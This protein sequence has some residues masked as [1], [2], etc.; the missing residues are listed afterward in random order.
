MFQKLKILFFS[1]SVII[2]LLSI[3]NY[4][5]KCDDNINVDNISK[6]K[7]GLLAGLSQNEHDVNF[8]SLDG[9]PNCCSPY[10]STG[11]S[12]YV[13]GIEGSYRLF[14]SIGLQ[15]R[16]LSTSFDVEL[17]SREFIGN[18]ELSGELIHIYSNHLLKSSLTMF[19]ISPAIN[20]FPISSIDFYLAM[21]IN[22]GKFIKYK[23][24]QEESLDNDVYEKGIEY[25]NGSENQGIKRNIIDGNLNV[26]KLL[27]AISP[28]IG[29]TKNISN[30][31]NLGLQLDYNC[32]ISKVI[33]NTAWSLR[34][35]SLSMNISY[36]FNKPDNNSEIN[37][38]GIP[39]EFNNIDT[40]REPLKNKVNEIPKD[41]I[42]ENKTVTPPV[43]ANIKEEQ[44]KPKAECCYV[45]FSYSEKV[46]DIKNLYNKLIKKGIIEL[47][48]V[49][50]VDIKDNIKYFRLVSNCFDSPE[51]AIQYVNKVKEIKS[52]KRLKLIYFIKCED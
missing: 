15:I 26:N 2:I 39:V 9:F 52:L 7:F 24:H 38:G 13:L 11:N 29:Y 6:L 18:Q 1:I 5:L 44:N 22:I 25:F 3:N 31:I 40:N 42:I 28:G 47:K 16:L 19:S 35:F 14:E 43:A 36:A 34:S 41:E 30:N 8:I 17:K 10:H 51:N 20:Y 32:W 49:D 45:I 37:T 46:A 21:G 50:Y 48:I 23:G 12:S 4:E 33:P 27:F